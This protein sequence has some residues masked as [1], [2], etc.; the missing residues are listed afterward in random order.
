MN[1]PVKD[2]N[3][4]QR[5]LNAAKIV[6]Q[7]K[8]MAGARMQEIAEEAGVNK[9]LLNYYF[10]SKEKLFEVIFL[11]AAGE[12][13]PAV[14]R[15]LRQDM[16]FE[17][18]VR[19]FAYEYA[20]KIASRPFLPLF[21]MN[22]INRDPEYFMSRIKTIAPLPDPTPFIEQ[23]QGEI[24]AGR[25]RPISPIDLL[26][27]VMSLCAFPAIAKPMFKELFKIDDDSFK[28]VLEARRHSVGEFVL[29]AI[30]NPHV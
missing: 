1:T 16:S 17:E 21:V 8:G 12:F 9:A 4:E 6:F 15:L 29:A 11:E 3:A 24:E 14:H 18:R 25:I 26:V 10:R 20:S 5:I 13:L 30:K 7:R 19:A 27:N 28:E 22:E 23:M 2:E